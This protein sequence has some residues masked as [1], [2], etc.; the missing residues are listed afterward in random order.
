MI[1]NKLSI[2][3]IHTTTLDSTKANIIQVVSMCNAF[4]ALGCKV[5][6]ATPKPNQSID[7]KKYIFNNFGFTLKFELHLYE[8]TF[9]NEKLEKYFVGQELK[10]L[11]RNHKADYVFLRNP[12]YIK[13]AL[14]SRKMVIFESHNNLI[15][16]RV[17][18][19]DRFWKYRLKLLIK[20]KNFI[21]FITISKSLFNSWE[22]IGI[23]INKMLPLHDGFNENLFKEKIDKDDSRKR[24]KLPLDKII[25]TYTGSLY[26]NRNIMG[27]INLAKNKPNL[28][29]L[30]IGGPVLNK[31]KYETI[32][33]EM[34]LENI[35]FL[36]FIQH[37]KITQY[38]FASDILLALWS[39]SVPTI[40]YCSPLKL[41]EYMASGK[42]ILAHGFPSVKEVLV[43]EH[44]CLLVK[45]ED[46][47]HLK[48][49]LEGMLKMSDKNRFGDVARK[50]AF[51]DYTWTIRATKISKK[52]NQFLND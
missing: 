25:V 15:H 7:I 36:G 16:E 23:P 31:I 18:I 30:I 37:K 40:N 52:I 21:L 33:T 42:N 22:K 17:K 8:R 51:K 32:S 28:F 50:E 6:L 20:N 49:Q 29:F 38:L 43:N 11:I 10:K 19:I 46:P 14:D 26:Q 41:F 35:I 13:T 47:Q 39:K 45:P 1:N 9:K 3:Y 48:S 24:L 12:K 4:S 34:G 27:I 2:L 5:T 44:N